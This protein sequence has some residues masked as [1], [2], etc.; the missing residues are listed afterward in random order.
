VMSPTITARICWARL[1]GCRPDGR[2]GSAG[3]WL[4]V[5]AVDGG[6]VDPVG[7]QPADGRQQ[8]LV[9]VAPV[10]DQRVGR[11]RAHRGPPLEPGLDEV[12]DGLAGGAAVLSGADLA[13]EAGF[14]LAGLGLGRGGAGLLALAAGKWVAAG[15]DDDPPA[16]APLL[17]HQR[18]P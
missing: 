16:V 17:D 4:G 9:G 8:L 7:R 13:D 2:P 14:E 18:A 5:E 6:G 3:G 1:T 10:V 12:G 15:V 11:D